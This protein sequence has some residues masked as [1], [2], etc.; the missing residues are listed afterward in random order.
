MLIVMLK[1]RKKYKYTPPTQANGTNSSSRTTELST[2]YK[3]VADRSPDSTPSVNVVRPVKYNV[4]Q[5]APHGSSTP[6]APVR[7]GAGSNRPPPPSRPNPPKPL[8]YAPPPPTKAYTPAPQHASSSSHRPAPAPRYPVPSAAKPPPPVLAQKPQGEYPISL[9]HTCS[10]SKY[11]DLIGQ[12]ESILYLFPI[13][14]CKNPINGYEIH[15]NY[16]ALGQGCHKA[17][18]PIGSTLWLS[19]H[20][21]KPQ[22][23]SAVCL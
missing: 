15:S 8:S 6:S 1:P 17:P 19:T 21:H 9:D 11:C 22:H 16:G 14:T 5:R 10:C 23:T 13:D 3:K 4:G 7:T 20:N 2:T 18:Y 12:E